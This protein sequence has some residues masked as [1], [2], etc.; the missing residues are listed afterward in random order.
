MYLGQIAGV[1]TICWN[2]TMST[3][4]RWEHVLGTRSETTL[5]QAINLLE[6][7]QAF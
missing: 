7:L 4:F 3:Q 5:V 1:Q 6:G 2:F